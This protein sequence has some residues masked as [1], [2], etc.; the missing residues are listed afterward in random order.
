MFDQ[1]PEGATGLAHVRPDTAYP[2]LDMTIGDCLRDKA[3]RFGDR[4]ALVWRLDDKLQRLT[5]AE[6]LDR[7]ELVASWLLQHA[8]PGDRI[9]IWSRNSAEWVLT[10]YAC[11][12]AGMV[13][14]SW[15]PAWSERECEHARDLTEPALVLAGYDTRGV[16]LMERA[17]QLMPAGQSFPLEDLFD[18][19]ADSPR[20]EMPQVSPADLFLIQFTSGTT[21]RS[22]GA[23]L[24]HFAALNA[25]YFRS[26]AAG[27]DETDVWVNAGPL[28]HVGGALSVV[29]GALTFGACFVLMQ[30]FDTTEY[31]RMMRET[32][33]TRIGGVPTMLIALCEH[34]EWTPEAFNIR[35]IGSGGA[36]VPKPLIERL[37]REFGAPVLVVFGQSESVM[38][39]SS[40]PGDPPEIAAETSGR[41]APHVEMKICDP[42]TGE[43]LKV[44]QIGEICARSPMIMDGYFRM[45]EATASTI[46]ADG[47]LHTGDLGSI[48]AEGYLRIHGRAR[49]GISRG[50]ENIYPAE[51]E[52]Y[53]LEHPDI[54]GI[55]VVPVADERWGQTVAAAVKL[56]DGVSLDPAA[57]EEFAAKGLA[58][59]KIPRTW[60]AVDS[61]PLTASG[62]VRKVEVEK[63]FEPAQA[64]A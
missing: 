25:A 24:S 23:A 63:L 36:A 38:I 4:N 56:R 61:F 53:L 27:M 43:T 46:D 16:S 30:K 28:N 50:G 51:I 55:A 59:F 35:S 52:D 41:A 18:L 14:A 33:A 7:A 13:V 1:K 22:K 2:L 49:E 34:P 44:G 60:R 12:L 62:K 5:Y 6:L 54:Q 21:G 10:E 29:L 47:F 20:V 37:N 15:N 48:D 26:V 9:A 57:L 64:Q 17:A 45:P 32:G 31:L 40:V 19:I 42:A 39:T 58:H 11:A 8:K 3:D